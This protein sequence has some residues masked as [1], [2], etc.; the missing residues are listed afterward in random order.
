M[1]DLNHAD[2]ITLIGRAV[3]STYRKPDSAKVSLGEM[4]QLEVG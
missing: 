3:E 1:A 2:Y 4:G